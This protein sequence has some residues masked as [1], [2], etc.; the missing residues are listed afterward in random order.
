[1]SPVLLTCN[2]LFFGQIFVK[3]GCVVL[4]GFPPILPWLD[5]RKSVVSVSHCFWALFAALLRRDILCVNEPFEPAFCKVIPMKEP[6]DSKDRTLSGI[7]EALVG[8]YEKHGGIN[9]LEGP[10]LPSRESVIEIL[11]DLLAVIFPGYY[12]KKVITR[13]NVSSFVGDMLTSLQIRLEN[14]I[15]RS[16]KYEC[17]R[18]DDC[19]DDCCGKAAEEATM[20]LLR[21]LPEIR[22]TLKLDVSAAYEGDPAAKSHDEIILSYPNTLA[23]ATYRLA[24][25][26][27][28]MEAA[29]IA[30][31]MSEH[32]HRSTGIDIHPG[33]RIG[34]YFFIDHGTGV[35]IGET[36]HIGDHVKIYQGVT[37]GALSFPQDKDGKIIK[38]GKRHP[39][40][41]DDVTIYSG[42]TL[43]GG[44]TVI[45][46]GSDIGG[47]VWLT[48][49]VPPG[50]RVRMERQ[51]LKM[52]TRNTGA[53]QDQVK[54][55]VSSEW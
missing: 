54:G 22:E 46:K 37:L 8:T 55:L 6:M 50:T 18:L 51:K 36:T 12:G 13:A 10:N 41:E 35:V 27:Y 43:L 25:E 52:S 11:E 19:P 20:H 38:G 24:H 47:N 53:S 4:F 23:I 2:I 33:A 3:R 39:T 28:A 30:R 34:R 44:K 1:M 26:L 5:P 21:K 9:H 7:V 29:L 15:E 48:E 16:F 31:I 49:S 17:R 42:A 45:G 32:A 14:E 40:I